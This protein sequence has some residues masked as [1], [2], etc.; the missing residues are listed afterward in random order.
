MPT[1]K[2][3]LK[4][5]L[6]TPMVLQSNKRSILVS[7]VATPSINYVSCVEALF[8]LSQGLR[9]WAKSKG[10]WFLITTTSDM[11]FVTKADYFAVQEDKPYE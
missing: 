3:N 11:N 8:T 2:T 7:I 5:K 9:A 10:K 4:Q 6:V 1:A